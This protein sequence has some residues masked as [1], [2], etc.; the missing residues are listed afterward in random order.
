LVIAPKINGKGVYVGRFD[1]DYLS[2]DNSLKLIGMDK[3][4]VLNRSGEKFV[5]DII[6]KR[7]A[8]MYGPT[9]RSLP[10]QTNPEKVIVLE[11]SIG[12]VPESGEEIKEIS[13]RAIIVNGKVID[14][15]LVFANENNMVMVPLRAITEA[16]GYTITWDG[17]S[18]K[19][20]LSDEITLQI[21]KDYYIY[22][23]SAAIELG[24]APK[25][26]NGRT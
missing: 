25:S 19:V 14:V 23:K 20:T 9:T 8:V 24:N 7:V 11:E 18:K 26:V 3:A 17:E 13:C 5:G 12:A 16:L 22:E 1:K 6:N 15:S 10:P 4:V 21:G 2:V